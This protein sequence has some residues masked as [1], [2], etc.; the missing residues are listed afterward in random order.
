MKTLL[1]VKRYESPAGK[2]SVGEVITVEDALYDYLMRD[3]PGCFEE[4]E[5][6]L[7]FKGKALDE[8]PE[9]KMMI[10]APKKKGRVR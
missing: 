6:D 1:V 7:P 3:A 9:D 8:P 2:W 5:D 4:E 10:K